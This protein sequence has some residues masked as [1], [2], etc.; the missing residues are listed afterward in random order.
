MRERGR[1]LLLAIPAGLYAA[2]LALGKIV[3]DC[4]LTC[5]VGFRL[6]PVAILAIA[7]ATLPLAAFALR[8]ERRFG[9]RRWQVGSLAVGA[10]TLI[11]FRAVSHVLLAGGDTALRAGASAA[12][13]SQAL[14]WT[15]LAF[16]VWIGALSAVLGV[17]VFSHAVR[18]FP[19]REREDAIPLLPLAFA[20]GG[21][22]GSLAAGET[23]GWFARALGWRYETVRDNL[24]F[25]MAACLLL[26]IPFVSRVARRT[27]DPPSSRPAAPSLARQ[28]GDA[29]RHPLVA[30]LAAVVILAGVADTTLKY[31]FYW[32]VSLQVGYRH[33]RTLYFAGFYT[34]LNA[35]NLLLLAAGSRRA[36]RRLG[37]AL[38]LATLPAAIAAGGVA[39]AWHLSISLMYGVRVVENALRSILYEPAFDRTVL[40]IEGAAGEPG[41]F[42]LKG[43]GPRAGEGLGA[44]LVLSLAAQP[45][46]GPRGAAVVLLA[47]LAAWLAAVAALVPILAEAHGPKTA[48]PTV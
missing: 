30:G 29:L 14:R 38:S 19:G 27:L 41:R 16:Y 46:F 48:A 7:A 12:T 3:R 45:G 2:A 43:L 40:R 33:G 10:A 42:L 44:V 47:V 15:Y 6:A 24:I 28:F 34:W 8:A 22:A 4:S 17:N 18:L 39:L 37:V 35:A 31:L 13:W 26:Q 11:A 21:L 5:N 20:I 25:A 9:Y 23:A 36:V 1:R 32:L